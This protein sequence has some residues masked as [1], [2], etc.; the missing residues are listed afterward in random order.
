M[1]K[2]TIRVLSSIGII[3][4]GILLASFGFTMQTGHPTNTSCFL[5]GLGVVLLGV[6][7]FIKIAND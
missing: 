2:Q 4:F 5:L 6:V 1:L 3:L 7:Y